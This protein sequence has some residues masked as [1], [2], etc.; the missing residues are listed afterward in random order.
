MRLRFVFL[1]VLITLLAACAR[2]VPEP[3]DPGLIP[4]EEPGDPI[5]AIP[6]A[7]IGATDNFTVNITGALE[8]TIPPGD[9]D[10]L[11]VGGEDLSEEAEGWQLTFSREEDD[12]EYTVLVVLPAD[13]EVGTH[14]LSDPGAVGG[15]GY[16]AAFTVT[17]LDCAL[18]G[19]EC[20]TAGYSEGVIGQIIIAEAEEAL[21]GELTF[22]AGSDDGEG[23]IDVNGA[24][25]EVP[26]VSE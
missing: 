16:T 14:N 6:G 12:L 3:A 5:T 21:S 10:L 18:E 11:P 17:D 19:D 24:F 22:S 8:L 15:S 20:A 26:F 4:S 13:P 9:A 2:P 1:L 7:E 25:T 23:S